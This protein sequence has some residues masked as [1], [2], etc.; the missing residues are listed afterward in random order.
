M[1]TIRELAKFNH[2][3]YY[4]D[5]HLYYIDALHEYSLTYIPD[6]H[7]IAKYEYDIR[8]WLGWNA[9]YQS[10]YTLIQILIKCTKLSAKSR[11]ERK[12]SKHIVY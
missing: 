6:I 1:D 10:V 12:G 8:I 7:R 4:D 5:P 9:I 11:A 2:I 3:K